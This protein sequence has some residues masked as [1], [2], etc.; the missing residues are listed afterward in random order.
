MYVRDLDPS[1]VELVRQF[2][3]AHGWAHRVGSEEQFAQLV[4]NAQRT[5]VAFA[6]TQPVGFAR[7]ITDGISNGYL[8]MVVVSPEHRR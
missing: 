7:A 1:E 8:S 6:G 2:L 5:A 4:A 3:G